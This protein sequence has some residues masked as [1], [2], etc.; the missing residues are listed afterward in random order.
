MWTCYC[1]TFIYVLPAL[2]SQL[3]VFSK[4][5][6]MN[7]L[8]HFFLLLFQLCRSLRN[9]SLGGCILGKSKW[10]S[11]LAEYDDV[12]RGPLF[13]LASGPPNPKPTTGGGHRFWERTASFSSQAG[14]SPPVW[15]EICN[16]FTERSYERLA[17]QLTKILYRLYTNFLTRFSLFLKQNSWVRTWVFAFFLSS[18]TSTT[19]ELSLNVFTL[20]SNDFL[21]HE[22]CWFWS[23][24]SCLCMG[25]VS[26]FL[27]ERKRHTC[28]MSEN[29]SNALHASRKRQ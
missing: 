5:C 25:A 23:R 19:S 7:T 9:I 15:P 3:S 27:H 11:P 22:I 18:F 16:S 8:L 2:S 17:C 13:S 6:I 29:E 14:W 4:L 20:D 24:N 10:L 12:I 26:T 28:A 21:S 1:L